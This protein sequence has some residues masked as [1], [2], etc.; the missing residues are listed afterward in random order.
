MFRSPRILTTLAV[1]GLLAGTASAETIV[2]DESDGALYDSILDGAYIPPPPAPGS[3]APKDNVPDSL[4]TAGTIAIAYHATGIQQVGVA[5]LPLAELGALDSD[6]IDTAILTFRI[7]DVIGTFWPSVDG[8]ATFD[9]TAADSIAVFAYDA[10]GTIALADFNN[11]IGAPD[12]VVVTSG[13]PGSITDASL[14]LSGALSFDVDLTDQLKD[15]IDAGATHI[16]IVFATTD[17]PT[18]TS[19]DTTPAL[20]GAALP[21]LTV[22]TVV[23]EPPV[24]D[25]AERLCQK[26]LALEGRKYA[27][28]AHT[29]LQICFDRVLKDVAAAKPLT[30]AMAACAKALDLG[31]SPASKIDNARAKAV[32][33][34]QAKCPAPLTP[35]DLNGPCDAGATTLADVATCVLDHNLEQVQEMVR[36]EYADACGIATGAALASDYPVVCDAP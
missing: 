31:A 14:A 9:G 19:L 10:D 13:S 36:A 11:V 20:A 25:T 16:G 26:A 5:E 18:G 35:A 2:I 8:G 23:H 3:T 4:G 33:K 34:V 12:G 15:L 22:E 17:G 28:F 32:T 30:N 21:F 6:D 24:F 27:N 7:N 29:Q 1:A